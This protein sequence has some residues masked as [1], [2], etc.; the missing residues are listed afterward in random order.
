MMFNIRMVGSF[1]VI[2]PSLF[3]HTNH[4]YKKT[5]WDDANGAFLASLAL[6]HI[7]LQA[8]LVKNIHLVLLQ[9]ADITL[10]V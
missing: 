3:T 7:N 4:F 2:P 10:I 9:P 5:K 8:K 1:P 6:Q